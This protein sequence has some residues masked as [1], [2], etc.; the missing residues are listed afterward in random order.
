MKEG[1]AEISFVS[2][3]TVS[4][5]GNMNRESDIDLVHLRT[6]SEHW[7]GGSGCPLYALQADLYRRNPKLLEVGD[8]DFVLTISYKTWRVLRNAAATGLS[9]GRCT[10]DWERDVA[11]KIMYLDR[12]LDRSVV[13]E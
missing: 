1:R 3:E 5:F 13:S 8:G 4:I 9:E 12:K 7:H 2:E 10:E 6:F 11:E